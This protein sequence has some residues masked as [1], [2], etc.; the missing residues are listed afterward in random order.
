MFETLAHVVT[1]VAACRVTFSLDS[2][3]LLARKNINVSQAIVME[4]LVT[5][6]FIANFPLSVSVKVF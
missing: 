1:T 3:H 5:Y 2:F 6:C 4:S